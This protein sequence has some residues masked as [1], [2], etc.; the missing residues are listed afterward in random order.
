MYGEAIGQTN[1]ARFK[2][3][4]FDDIYRRMLDLPALIAIPPALPADPQE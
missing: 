3:P 1:L 4:A 2:L